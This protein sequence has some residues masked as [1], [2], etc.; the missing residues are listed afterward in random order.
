VQE[1]CSGAV[2]PGTTLQASD[3]EGRENV[4][5]PNRRLFRRLALRIMQECKDIDI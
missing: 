5:K 1:G 2:G 4:R 3:S